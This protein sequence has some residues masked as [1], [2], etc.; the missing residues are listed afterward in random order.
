MRILH[1]SK[2]YPPD[3]GGLEHVVASLAEGA[4]AAGHEVRVVCARGSRW[5]GSAARERAMSARNGVTVHRVATAGVL[6]SQ[7]ISP[8]YLGAARWP[9]DVVYVHRPHPL[10]D[11]AAYLTRPRG[12]LVFHHSDVQRQRSFRAIYQPL[13][14]AVAAR[15]FAAVIGARA[16]LRHASDLGP[17]G[18]ARARVIPFGV[19]E[20]RFAPR[21]T[22]NVRRPEAFP[23]TDRVVGLFVGRLV[24]YKGLDVLVRAVAGTTLNVVIVGQGP[25]RAQVEGD[26]ERLGIADQVRL[27]ARVSERELPAYYQTAD[28]LLLPSTS[29]A[30]MFGVTMLEAMAC[31]KPVISS[32]VDSGMREVNVHDVTGLQVPPRDHEALRAAMQRMAGDETLRAKMGAAG[33]RRVEEK[34]TL[35]GMIEAHLELCEELVGATAGRSQ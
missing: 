30:E 3:P 19:D 2:F 34:F 22:S 15:A 20:D 12:L 7:P 29:P 32:S 13:A 25:M 4:A 28:Y 26:I 33:R 6:W 23:E 5:K 14:H 1:L 18:T 17:A 35:K 10:A 21:P 11:L 31:G 16:N 8:G 27:V 9:A 24:S